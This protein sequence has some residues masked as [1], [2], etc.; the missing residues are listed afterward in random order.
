MNPRSGLGMAMMA[1]VSI[2]VLCVGYSLLL[3]EVSLPLIDLFTQTAEVFSPGGPLHRDGPRTELERRGA[4]ARRA[5]GPTLPDD[6]PMHYFPT[7]D[8]LPE[9]FTA[10]PERDRSEVHPDGGTVVRT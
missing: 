10:W 2:A 5:E 7:A 3:G 4:A 6:F 8:D 9:E 1:V